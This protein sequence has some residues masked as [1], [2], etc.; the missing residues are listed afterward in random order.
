MF[1]Q[2]I[3]GRESKVSKRYEVYL[4]QT[5]VPNYPE[6]YESRLKNMLPGHFQNLRPKALEAYD[7]I[8]TKLERNNQRDREDVEFLA[9][10]IPLDAEILRERYRKEFRPYIVDPVAQSLD[11]TLELWVDAYFPRR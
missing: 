9:K 5:G 3:G 7:L 2:E 8:L 6:D 4:Q 10:K 11:N 1:L